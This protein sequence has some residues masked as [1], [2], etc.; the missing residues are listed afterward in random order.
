MQIRPISLAVCTPV[1]TDFSGQQRTF[2]LHQHSIQLA[3]ASP[4]ISIYYPELTVADP[5]NHLASLEKDP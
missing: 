1:F 5:N 2:K 4:G 3:D